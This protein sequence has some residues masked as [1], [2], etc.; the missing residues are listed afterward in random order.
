MAKFHPL[1]KRWGTASDKVLQKMIIIF[2]FSYQIYIIDF[3]IIFQTEINETNLNQLN[4]S[5]LILFRSHQ[6]STDLQWKL[7]IDFKNGPTGI[8]KSWE[9]VLVHC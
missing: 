4:G 8:K 1:K 9:N 6:N 3:F 2:Q 5:C 7:A